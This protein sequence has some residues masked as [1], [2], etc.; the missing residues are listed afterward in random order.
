MTRLLEHLTA[1]TGERERREV[2]EAT[3]LKFVGPVTGDAI[4]EAGFSVQ[5]IVDKN[6]SYRMLLEAG[7]NA[8]VA[9]K[10]RRY[11]SLSWSFDADGDLSRRSEQV[12]GLQDEERAWVADSGIGE[13]ASDETEE[14]A[15]EEA[16]WVENAS[17]GSDSDSDG[18]WPGTDENGSASTEDDA[19]AAWVADSDSGA[20]SADGSGDPIAAEAAWRERS[21]PTP[22]T[23]VSGIGESYS[24]KLAEA[25]VT[26]VR[27]LATANPELLSDVTGI[28]EE[29]VSKWHH[30]ASNLAE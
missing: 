28:P 8:G 7:V 25:G 4:E 30:E 10:I 16:A 21:K 14:D 24:T 3:D 23:E 19:E 26:S 12:R 29:K 18:D 11:H 22:L 15:D 2:D 5:D 9:A 20:T 13:N 27:S 6:V 17:A 1:G